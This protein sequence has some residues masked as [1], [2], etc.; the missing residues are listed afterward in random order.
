MKFLFRYVK[1]YPIQLLLA[2]FGS[3]CFVIVRLGLPTLLS[4]II[5]GALANQSQSQLFMFIMLM[6]FI[7]FLGLAGQLMS[8]FFVSSLSN[9]I[10]KDLRDDVYTKIQQLSLHEFQSLGV[11]SLSTRLTNDAF[12]L[13]QFSIMLLGMG[14][15]APIMIIVSIF[16]ILRLSVRMG[17]Y[18]SP[19][20]PLIILIIILIV[21]I[22]HP[23]SQKQQRGLDKIN[24][25]Q[26]ENITGLRVIRAFNR[27][28][29]QEERFEESNESYRKISTK[30]F[31]IVGSSQPGF[32]FITEIGIAMVIWLGAGQIS[33]GNLQVGDVVAFIEYV[34][35]ALFSLSLFSTIFLMYPRAAVSSERLQEII[36]MP[37]SVQNPENPKTETDGSGRLEFKNVSFS[38]PDA[39]EPTLRDISFSSKAGQT[40]AFIGSTGSGKSTIVKLIPRFYDV[41]KGQILLDG[42]DIRELDLKT[43]REKIGYTPQRANLFTGKISDNL[44]YGNATADTADLSRASDIS[45]A[46]EFISRTPSG[47]DTH[48]SEGGNNLSGGQKQRLSI[49]RSIIGEHE[50]YVFDDSFSALDY[51]TDATV[52]AKLA[53]ETKDATTIIVAQRVATIMHADQIIVLDQGRIAAKGTHKELLE[54]SDLYHEIAASQLSEE[55]LANA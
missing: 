33:A 7:V 9:H 6:L 12:L 32:N 3:I 50:V 47:L 13:M 52:R 5:D 44:R 43:L 30:L 40:I 37:I 11:P 10:I 53:E 21:K 35:E 20:L 54:T 1:P 8:R 46:A 16:M 29:Y 19:A 4:Y 51:K 34:F 49:A 25:I 15:T 36:D 18:I 22:T 17:L 26:R 41:T 55:E 27:E 48:L 38:Y 39:D 42:V 2:L 28:P 45:Q 24:R 31:Q 14:L 23:L